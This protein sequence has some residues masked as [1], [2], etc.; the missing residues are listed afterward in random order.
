MT[1]AFMSPAILM[2]IASLQNRG[3]IMCFASVVL[4]LGAAFALH[5]LMHRPAGQKV[6]F[7]ILA[8][9][10]IFMSMFTAVRNIGGI[11][12]TAAQA[13]QA[14]AEAKTS[15]ETRR[16]TLMERRKAQAKIAGEDAAQV[17]EGNIEALKARYAR[18]WAAT[19]GCQLDQ[20]TSTEAKVLCNGKRDLEIKLA[21]AVERDR[22]QAQIDSLDVKAEAPAIASPIG[23]PVSNDALIHALAQAGF[24][25]D[26]S[27]IDYAYEAG[28]VLALELI[29]A[30][31]PLMFG[32]VLPDLRRRRIE[33]VA[34]E[35]PLAAT[36]V[37]SPRL[38]AVTASLP[39]VL[40][41]A[42]EAVTIPAGD[43]INGATEALRAH[44]KKA[45]ET[46]ARK[47]RQAKAATVFGDVDAW[48]RYRTVVRAG[49]S[50]KAQSAYDDYCL[51]CTS[52]K[53]TPFTF[54]KFGGEQKAYGI[55]KAR[56]AG[57]LYYKDVALAAKPSLSVVNKAAS[58]AYVM[59]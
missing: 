24:K 5:C 18:K 35:V 13:R 56:R 34:A 37:A 15:L 7:L 44:T 2:N 26:G 54:A 52:E 38:A 43:A 6:F 53:C 49:A 32:L 57:G 42:V 33:L 9:V 45:S 8:P 36:K 59:A 50:V 29:A 46:R 14:R 23:V 41:A 51:W 21:A 12:E 25:M 20:V 30:G 4:V 58:T 11:R 17:I 22:I 48:R 16:A 55:E 40:A 19:N 31:A 47:K 10:L 28:F 3:Q 39:P 27:E 1:L